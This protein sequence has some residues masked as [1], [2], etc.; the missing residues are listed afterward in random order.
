MTM[1]AATSHTGVSLIAEREGVRLHAYQDSR[2]LWTIGVGHLSSG[3]FPVSPG[4]TISMDTALALLASDL[5]KVEDIIHLMVSAPL[6][7]YQFDALAS[8]G[9]NI[10]GGALGKSSVVRLI[11]ARQ[12]DAAAH[13]FMMWVY[14]PELTSRRRAEAAQFKG[15]PPQVRM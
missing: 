8:L 9:F 6:T 10:G 14:P 4:Q 13:A 2:G 11:N 3:G 12:Y 15:L 5:K 1:P 7:Q